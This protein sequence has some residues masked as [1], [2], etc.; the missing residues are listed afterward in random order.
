M[1][2]KF[3]ITIDAEEDNW[4]EYHTNGATVKNI[5]RISILQE[6]F[7][8]YGAIPTYLV[9]YPV[10]QSDECEVIRNIYRSGRCSVGSHCHPWNTSPFEEELNLHNSMLCNLPYTLVLAKLDTLHKA[11]IK[12]FG[13]PPRCFRAGRWGFGPQVARSIHKMG[14]L[15]DTSVS[16]FIDWSS[17]GGP[18]Y[19]S[20]TMI[21]YR[22]NYNDIR[23]I[24]SRGCL[25][26]VPATVGFW[27]KNYILCSRLR[28]WIISSKLNKIHLLGLLDRLRIV[29]LRWLSPELSNG[30]EMITLARSII[31]S[32]CN[33]LNM[34]FHSTS[35]LP[36]KGPF[37]R[38]ENDLEDFF[39]RIDDILK[40]ARDNGIIFAPLDEAHK[41]W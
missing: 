18:D 33:F 4:G 40:F 11:I 36:G 37:V 5:E 15:V 6:L 39:K 38:S 7:D 29:N 26:E 12:R 17:D 24:D 23:S 2:V 20:T 27:Q 10:A 22:F 3:Y 28:K 9:N 13:D 8:K 1:S 41:I 25:V 16:P 14:Y 19:T 35:L 34:S 32:G 30:N 31:R 21:K